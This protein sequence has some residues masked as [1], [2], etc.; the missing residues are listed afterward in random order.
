MANTKVTQHVISDNAITTAMITDAN[1]THAKLHSTMDLSG[2]TVTLPAVAIPSASTATTQSAL[3]NSTKVATTSYVDSAVTALIDSAPSGLNTLNELAAA[4]NDD[5]SFSS[6][7]TTSLAAKA[8][9]ASPSFTGTVQLLDTNFPD[10]RA[11]RFGDSQDLQIY[12]DGTHSYVASSTGSLYIRTGNTLQIEN[13]SGSEDLA[14][15]AVNGAATL[16]YDNDAKLATAAYGVDAQGTGALK[17][18]VGTTA[19]RPTAATG[20][21]RWNSTDGAI[22]VYNGSAWT[23]VGTGSSNKVLNTFTGD[24]STT[25]FTLTITPANEDALMVFIDG[26]YQEA[27]DYVLTNNSLALDTAPLSGEKVSAHIT[28]ASIHDGT[29]ALNQAFTGDGSTTAFTLSQDPKSENNTQVYINGVYQQK[30]DYTVSG[31]T[32]TFDTAPTSGDIIEVN[33]FTVATLGNS[34]T[35]TEGSSNLYHTSARAISA[36]SD[37]TLTGNLTLKTSVDNSVAQGLAIE[38]SANSD[39]G[40]INYNGGAFQMRS[41]VGDP[42][43]F[44]ETDAEHMRIAPDGNVG[45]GTSSP[46]TRL[47][48]DSSD[49]SGIRISRSASATAYMQLFP[50]YSNVP[51]IMGLGAGGLHLGYNS[52]TAGIRIDTNNNV[53]IGTSSPSASHKLTVSGDTKLTGQLSMLDNQLIKMGDGEDFAIYHDTSAGNVIKSNTSDMDIV[54]QGNDGGS[55]VTALT[56]DMS[57]N[58]KALFGGDIGFVDNGTAFFG[59]SG[60]LKIYHDGA[61]SYIQN[62]TNSLIIQNDSDDRHV[63]IKSDDGSGGVA[64]YFRAKGDTG[65]AI[66]Y[67]YGSE[68]LAT[69]STGVTVTGNVAISAS[70]GDTLTLTKST[71]EPSLRLEGDANKDF[72]FTVSGELLTLTQNDG[73]TDIVTFDHDTKASVFKGEVGIGTTPATHYTGYVALDIGLVGS[74]FSNSS[75]TNVTTL[76]NNGF[77]NSNASQWTYKVT[78]E[79]TMYSQVHGDHRFSTA[80]SGSANGAITWSEKVRFQNAGGISFNGDTA[81]ANA[82]DDYEEGSWTPTASTSNGNGSFSVTVNYAKYIKVG[83]LVH[84]SCYL[85]IIVSNV[86]SG[87]AIIGG[88]PFVNTSGQG[89]S[90]ASVGHA[91]A[92][93]YHTNDGVAAYVT[94][95]HNYIRHV[96]VTDTGNVG[97][98]GTGQKYY[99]MSCTYHSV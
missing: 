81:A 93:Q 22:E 19:Q 96:N 61:N 55:S 82:L 54:I 1:I 83:G 51:T 74:L 30:T 31:T 85:S 95:G 20:Q 27:G 79:A 8:P 77:L 97:W 67:H 9:L 49:G 87:A 45:I 42:I 68:K 71:T 72:V 99:M 14:T 24:G 29:S 60:D 70:G 3:D 59:A 48:V 88:L 34:D 16:F 53:G 5:T 44:G 73:V 2:K 10:N 35:V 7:V 6:T 84:A 28:T 15:F 91:S 90:I 37:S 98:S 86:G 12:H 17:I 26:A 52:N 21:I 57:N 94:N 63:I 13:Q 50:A 33:M 38:R 47:H 66:L 76:T 46:Q 4:L 40:Y 32:L 64:D 25:T 75:G 80:A 43:A 62:I 39:K 56:F 23:A 89:Y 69:T 65:A 92:I 36:I 78:D 41:T 11:A 18:P 58:G